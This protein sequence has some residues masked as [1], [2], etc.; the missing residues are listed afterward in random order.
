LPKHG[1]SAGWPATPTSAGGPNRTGTARAARPDWSF[2]ARRIR[3]EA[4][5]DWD[6][7]VAVDRFEGKGGR[8]VRGRAT[9]TSHRTVIVGR[10]E[11]RASRGLVLA[12]GTQPAVP[13]IARLA[14]TPY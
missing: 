1:A 7:T 8:L 12:T 13:R 4:T 11:F 14:G 5:D 9:V 6:D 10:R 2:V 3:E